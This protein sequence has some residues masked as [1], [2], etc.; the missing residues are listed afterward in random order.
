MDRLVRTPPGPSRI[1][2]PIVFESLEGNGYHPSYEFN[3]SLSAE[4]LTSSWNLVEIDGEW[5][6]ID[7]QVSYGTLSIF[8]HVFHSG[9]VVLLV[10]TQ[11]MMWIII[12]K[13]FTF[14]QTLMILSGT[15]ANK[16]QRKLE[17]QIFSTHFPEEEKDQCLETTQSLADFSASVKCWPLFHK[18]KMNIISHS[19]GVINSAEGSETIVVETPAHIR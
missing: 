4:R 18:M 7:T 13:N 19:D 2:R 12:M 16:F 14:A 15:S 17:F 8:H 5:K 11:M 9:V 3:V 1:L 10:L 6:I